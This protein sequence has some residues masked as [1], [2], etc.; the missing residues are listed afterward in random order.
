ME[1]DTITAQDEGV[2]TQIDRGHGHSVNLAVAHAL[3]G[4]R[5]EASVVTL[6]QVVVSVDV[7]PHQLRSRPF[8]LE[9]VEGQSVRP[10]PLS[11][12][13]TTSYA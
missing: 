12:F 1:V 4:L 2:T 11:P 9:I 6:V 10:P 3:E 7:P 13:T 8:V 5:P